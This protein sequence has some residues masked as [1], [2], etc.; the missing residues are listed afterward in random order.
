MK[1]SLFD[2]VLCTLCILG[3]AA[4]LSIQYIN[5]MPVG[6]IKINEFKQKHLID[7]NAVI[8]EIIGNHVKLYKEYEIDIKTEI[9]DMPDEMQKIKLYING[10]FYHDFP[11][12][13]EHLPENIN[14]MKILLKE[15]DVLEIKNDGSNDILLN[16]EKRRLNDETEKE[17]HDN[18]HVKIASGNLERF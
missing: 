11:D 9:G 1:K 17:D 4:V 12:E 3:V 18:K 7:E 8:G 6:N 13:A 15:N 16:I 10:V 14:E 5:V 2:I